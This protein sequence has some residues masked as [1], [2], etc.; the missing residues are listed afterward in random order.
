MSDLAHLFVLGCLI[1]L[2]RA[3]PGFLFEAMRRTGEGAVRIHAGRRR[4][5]APASALSS[6]IDLSLEQTT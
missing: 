2:G 4:P 3:A 5:R 1:I 6:P